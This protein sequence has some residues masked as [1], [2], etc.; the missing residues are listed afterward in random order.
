MDMLL[1]YK[2]LSENIAL[3]IRQQGSPS[4]L[5]YSKLCPSHTH[6]HTLSLSQPQ[7]I[8]SF[9]FSPYP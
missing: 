2:T 3:A 7:T 6:T 9:S 4:N 1:I 5:F 8:K